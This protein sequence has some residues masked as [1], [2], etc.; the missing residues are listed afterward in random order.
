MIPEL[1][2]FHKAAKL[3]MEDAVEFLKREFSH[4]RAGRAT[5]SLLD[6]IKVDYYGT[7]TPLNQLANV[8]APEAHMLVLQPYDKSAMP[9]IEKAI[10]ASNLGLN[11]N[12]DG[13]LIRIPLPIL[14]EERR[15]ELVKLTHD[16]A[17]KARV[18]IRNA[19]RDA[20]DNI[21]KKV[22][23]DAL[24]EDSMYDAE[25]EIQQLTD[26]YIK[27]V[28]ELLSHKEKEILTV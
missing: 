27:H 1:K 10:Q 7:Q 3:E 22:K 20:N 19:R 8:S 17:E 25:T 24:S 15:K 2:S 4:I 12:N 11:P 18:S 14:S 21:K 16:T 28:D 26:D 23:D 9:N 13:T 5:P 6:G